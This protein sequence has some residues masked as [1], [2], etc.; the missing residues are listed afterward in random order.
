MD[1]YPFKI[2]TGEWVHLEHV[3]VMKCHN[4]TEDSV[5]QLHC[6]AVAAEKKSEGLNAIF[7]APSPLPLP[8]PPH[9]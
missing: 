1:P 8:P 7:L 2:S 6:T 9:K 5:T 3:C 4:P